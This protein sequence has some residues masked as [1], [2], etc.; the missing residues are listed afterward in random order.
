MACQDVGMI[1]RPSESCST[2]ITYFPK[3]SDRDSQQPYI[4][5]SL[6]NGSPF[7]LS[8][9]VPET[10][11]DSGATRAWFRRFF[12]VPPEGQKQQKLSP[13]WSKP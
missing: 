6:V 8:R 12:H 9:P 11:P 2:V 4:Q 5:V 13:C 10:R 7:R 3:C 1:R